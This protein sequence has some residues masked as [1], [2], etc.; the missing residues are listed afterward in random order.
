[1]INGTT[2]EQELDKAIAAYGRFLDMLWLRGL[3]PVCLL[4][5]PLPALKDDAPADDGAAKERKP[6]GI[7]R[8]QATEMTQA[9]NGRLKD[10]AA[11][12]GHAYADITASLMNERTGQADDYYLSDSPTSHHLSTERTA[13]LWTTAVDKVL[14]ADTS[15]TDR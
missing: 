15:S 8:A 1:M 4:G 11:A 7:S 5:V 14:A 9:Y 2:P 6:L 12:R 13:S 10:L 3:E